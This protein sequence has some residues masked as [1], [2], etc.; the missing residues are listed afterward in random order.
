MTYYIPEYRD[1]RDHSPF[2]IPHHRHHH[3]SLLTITTTITTTIT[4]MP[5]T[6]MSSDQKGEFE[7]LFLV[8]AGIAVGGVICGEVVIG[9]A[10]AAAGALGDGLARELEV[11]AAEVG[12]VGGVDG[13]R[14]RQFVEDGA[15]AACLETACR[16][17]ECVPGKKESRRGRM[18]G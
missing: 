17:C 2:L 8:E 12:S 18:S 6:I 16:C 15:E 9:E 5:A 3:C 14:L 11:H 10:L 13:E 7:C 4:I 1:H